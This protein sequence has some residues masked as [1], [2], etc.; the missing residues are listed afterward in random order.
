MREGFPIRWL[1]AAGWLVLSGSADPLSEIRARALSRFHGDGAIAYLS[2]ADDL[3]DA[4]MDDMAELGAPAGYFVDV[5]DSDNNVIYEQIVRAGMVVIEPG[6]GTQ[7]LQGILL[8]T[9]AQ[10]LKEAHRRGAL[11]LFEGAAATLAGEYAVGAN[12]R[13]R[14]GMQFVREAYIGADVRSPLASQAAQKV[15]QAQPAAVFIAIDRAAALVL[16]PQG[17]IETWGEG[18]LTVSLGT[19]AHVSEIESEAGQSVKQSGE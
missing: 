18:G 12:G 17:H 11:L 5:Q 13:I 2:L 1:D 15:H 6:R 16:G 7:S 9:V 14:S 10:A 4:L 8:P 19:A 3:G